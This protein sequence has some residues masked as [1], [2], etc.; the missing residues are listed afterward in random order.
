MSEG[1]AVQLAP[2]GVGVSALCPG[3]VNTRII[4]STRARQD[5]Y[6]GVTR[7]SFG[8][9]EER[10][11]QVRTAIAHGIDPDIVGQRVVEGVTNGDFYIF[12]K[13]E[14]SA[15]YLSLGLSYPNAGARAARF[16]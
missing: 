13:N 2:Q 11:E 10:T 15:F 5:R 9:N 8:A 6:G 12:T 1:W 14:K 16:A 7:P 4:D 3:F